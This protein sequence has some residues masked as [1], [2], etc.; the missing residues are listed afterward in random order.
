MEQHLLN[1]FDF[2]SIEQQKSFSKQQQL[3]LYSDT[4]SVVKGLYEPGMELLKEREAGLEIEYKTENGKTTPVTNAD[5]RISIEV[6]ELLKSIRDIPIVSEED[7]SEVHTIENQ[8]WWLI[9]PLDGTNTFIKGYDGFASCISLIQDGRPTL[10][11]IMFPEKKVVYYASEGSG[12]YKLNLENLEINRLD[13]R[14][15]KSSEPT[16]ATFF[17]HAKET[18]LYEPEFLKANGIKK[19]SVQKVSAAL[20]YCLV[21]EGEY[22]FG[23]GFAPIKIWDVS[24]A[25][26]IASE[27]FCKMLDKDNLPIEYRPDLHGV[28]SAIVTPIVKTKSN[29]RKPLR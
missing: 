15:Q 22:T 19:E 6:T 24:A 28:P 9:D 16:F 27:A 29:C 5:K 21:A 11:V 25:D 3:D 14:E 26:I 12:A 7:L 18:D 10:G 17:H 23:G 2:P 20:K 13:G 4:L 8:D 1:N